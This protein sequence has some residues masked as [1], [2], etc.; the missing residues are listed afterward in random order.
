MTFRSSE[1]VENPWLASRLREGEVKELIHEAS[2]AMEGEAPYL[3]AEGERVIFVGDTHG[4]LPS[5]IAAVK[6]FFSSKYDLLVF[7][8][9]YVDRGS[10]QVGNMNYVL[11]LK[12]EYPDRVI[13]LRGNHETPLAN[14]Y[15]GFIEAVSRKYSP[16]LYEAYV[17]I[18]SLLP[19]ACLLNE[20]ILCLH[21]GIAKELERLSQLRILP[22]EEDVSDPVAFQVLWNDP[23]EGIRGFSPSPRGPGIYVFGEDVFTD[24]ADRNGVEVM[25]RAHEAFPQGFKWYFKSRVL[26]LFS[27]ANYTIPVNAKIGEL[28]DGELRVISLLY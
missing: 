11:S 17:S 5:T 26:S 7:L 28:A 24:F 16:S 14:Q 9:D 21:G 22:R 2:K 19:Y 13:L 1:V 25:V 4:D 15:Y 18:F 27:A 23:Q 10:E 3:E 6:K 20:E 12:L 8:G